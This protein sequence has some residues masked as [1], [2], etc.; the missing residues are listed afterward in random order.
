MSG[1]HKV[2]KLKS[3]WMRPFS[4]EASTQTP[5]VIYHGTGSIYFTRR[6]DGQ[7]TP[8]V[9][10]DVTKHVSMKGRKHAGSFYYEYNAV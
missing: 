10:F 8:A 4:Q 2:L 1:G 5:H 6:S 3:V 9:H 7:F